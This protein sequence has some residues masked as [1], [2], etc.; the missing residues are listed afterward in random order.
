MQNSVSVP[1][2]SLQFNVVTSVAFVPKL[3]LLQQLQSMSDELARHT[4]NLDASYQSFDDRAKKMQ[5]W[6]MRDCLLFVEYMETIARQVS[7]HACAMFTLLG[8]SCMLNNDCF[9]T[10]V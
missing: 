3:P 8:S 9:V 4:V 6:V 1:K 2:L 5:R 7:F 10:A